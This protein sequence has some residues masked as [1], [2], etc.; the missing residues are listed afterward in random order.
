MLR[1]A[2]ER[3]V[4]GLATLMFDGGGVGA[5]VP[6]FTESVPARAVRL[7]TRVKLGHQRS[8]NCSTC[9]R[10]TACLA[11]GACR[12]ERLDRGCADR[13][14]RGRCQ[15]GSHMMHLLLGSGLRYHEKANGPGAQTERRG[16]AGPV[17]VLL[18]GWDSPAAF[19]LSHR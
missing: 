15:E 10:G 18:R 16:E 1:P 12:R 4:K 11:R 17:W 3:I 5:S 14:V 13:A 8:S 7:V 2:V 6:Q 19:R 9:K